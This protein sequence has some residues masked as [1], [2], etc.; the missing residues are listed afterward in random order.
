MPFL[1]LA[2]F[3]QTRRPAFSKLPHNSPRLTR[4][5][6]R[7]SLPAMIHLAQALHKIIGPEFPSPPNALPKLLLGDRS[8]RALQEI[9]DD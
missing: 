8:Q 2:E 7:I 5:D 6:R 3:L 9:R 1:E 4:M